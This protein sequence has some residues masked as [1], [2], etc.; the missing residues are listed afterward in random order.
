MAAF[1][2][3]AGH[4]PGLRARCCLPASRHR[5]YVAGSG[6]ACSGW[7]ATRYVDLNSGNPTPPYTS[8]ATAARNM[9]DA[10]DAAGS[11]DDIVVTNGVYSTGGRAVYGTMT[12]RVAVDKPLFVHSA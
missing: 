9:Q 11:G 6:A 4:A 2:G 7:A 8:W 5:M 1:R 10:V 3:P 12:N